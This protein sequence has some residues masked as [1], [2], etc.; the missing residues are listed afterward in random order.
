LGGVDL[1]PGRAARPA[2]AGPRTRRRAPVLGR[3]R[4]GPRRWGR[5]SPTGPAR[6]RRSARSRRRAH[7]FAWLHQPLV[8][9]VAHRHRLRATHA[10]QTVKRHRQKPALPLHRSKISS[11][12]AGALG[13]TGD[14]VTRRSPE[15]GGATSYTDV[16][17]RRLER[18]L[19]TYRKLAQ[20]RYCRNV[21]ETG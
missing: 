2:R 16:C 19:P 14:A 15:R 12:R 11:P 17:G 1:A 8:G 20:L 4:R 3:R 6:T 9:H 13:L 7:L 5:A 18:S 10:G 21:A